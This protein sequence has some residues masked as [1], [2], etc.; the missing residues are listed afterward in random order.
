MLIEIFVSLVAYAFYEVILKSLV[1]L[2]ILKFQHGDSMDLH[3]FPVLGVFR[4]LK[5]GD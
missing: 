1:P 3:Y 5:R 2:L 4:L